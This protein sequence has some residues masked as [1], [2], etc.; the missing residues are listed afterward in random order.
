[1]AET[2]KWNEQKMRFNFFSCFDPSHG[3]TSTVKLIKGSNLHVITLATK[4][5][6]TEIA[7]FIFDGFNSL[8]NC[9]ACSLDI[10]LYWAVKML[11][12]LATLADITN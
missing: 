12:L 5:I 6:H 7:S 10:R 1:M 8:K 9:T 2:K 3:K 4:S 11:I